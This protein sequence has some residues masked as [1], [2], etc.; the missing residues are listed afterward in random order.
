VVAVGYGVTYPLSLL[1]IVLLIQLAP[2]LMRQDLAALSARAA[3]RHPSRPPLASAM[4][5][6]LNPA[7]ADRPLAELTLIAELGCRV[8]RVLDGDRL[9]PVSFDWP[10]RLGSHVLVL[11]PADALP[12][13]TGY[14]GK[15]SDR[16]G[17]LDADDQ[18]MQQIG[19]LVPFADGAGL[20]V[21]SPFHLEGEA[22]VAP[23]R[24]PALGEHTDMV[25][26]EAG[27]TT[28]EIARLRAL[29]VVA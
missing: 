16:H 19:A 23:R 26:R 10:V 25:L 20:T 21:S 28:D 3:G 17:L 15:P 22:K 6:V 9:R 12:T 5:E 11:G 14:L 24:A 29:G 7:V 4:V 13:V 27:Y 2:K 8:L 1:A 18:Q